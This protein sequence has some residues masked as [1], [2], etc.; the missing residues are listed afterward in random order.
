M[1]KWLLPA[2]ISATLFR[3]IFYECPSEV[4][5]RF[6][7]A[8]I[9]GDR[10]V[11]LFLVMQGRIR[12]DKRPVMVRR[13][14]TKSSTSFTS[15]IKSTGWQGINYNWLCEAEKYA[16]DAFGYRLDLS[17]RKEMHWIGSLKM[18]FYQPTKANFKTAKSIFFKSNNKIRYTYL[19]IKHLFAKVMQVF[20]RDGLMVGLKNIKNK[21]LKFIKKYLKFR[22]SNEKNESNP[23]ANSFSK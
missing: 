7:S 8:Q 12:C 23:I 17:K 14:L 11:Y 1:E 20:K 15:A 6:E 5:E 19:L 18:C 22:K 13:V 3:N 21:S 10:R 4:L 2:H 9:L 16:L